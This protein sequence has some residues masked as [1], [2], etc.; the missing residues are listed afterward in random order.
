MPCTCSRYNFVPTTGT[1][2]TLTEM[3]MVSW[4][5][6]HSMLLH[7]QLWLH[8]TVY[9]DLVACWARRASILCSVLPP[10][11]P[12]SQLYPPFLSLS[13]SESLISQLAPLHQLKQQKTFRFLPDNQA[14]SVWNRDQTSMTDT[15]C[16]EG[17]NMQPDGCFP[18]PFRSKNFDS[19]SLLVCVHFSVSCLTSFT[20]RKKWFHR[21]FRSD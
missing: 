20:E 13:P 5:L 11:L 10:L 19:A 15:L 14:G 7:S 8:R 9:T 3:C 18:S 17:R 2:Q 16:R 12:A 6:Q 4:V 1:L 21:L